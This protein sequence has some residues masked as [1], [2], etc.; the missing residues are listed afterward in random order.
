MA[1]TVG[2]MF[3]GAAT[4]IG[5]TFACRSGMRLTGPAFGQQTP[6]TAVAPQGDVALLNALGE[7][8]GAVAKSVLPAVV[9]IEAIK[10]ASSAAAGAK[11]RTIDDSGSG[12]I[13]PSTDGAGY[14]VITNYHVVAGAK[15]EQ[16]SINL[17]DGRLVRPTRVLGDQETDIAVLKIDGT[18]LPAA[19]LGDSD[20]AKVGQWVI[21]LGSPYGLSQTVTHGIISAR[22]RGQVSL[23]P[24]IRVKD[25]LQTDAAINPGSSGGPLVNLNGEVVG[26][27]TA[28]A[29]QSGTNSGIAF[30]IPAN[31]VKRIT[32][33]LE[34][35][36]VV[37]HGYLG[38]Q[39]APVF[40]PADAIAFGLERGTGAKVDGVAQ[41]SPASRAGMKVNDVVL[42]VD[43]VLIRNDNHLINLISMLPP[44]QKVKL[45]VWRA[46][47]LTTVEAEVGDWNA[48]KAASRRQ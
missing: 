10:P 25:F 3:L 11:A 32:R 27:N 22:D 35:R 17:A 6:I 39:L 14:V 18:S 30:S 2:F 21:A 24:N 5:G 37:S 44:G 28:I 12:V 34:Q 41:D 45:Q 33:Q 13:L 16:V 46:K 19:K 8:F 1:R 26:I 47:K 20:K 7:R 40:E 15:P 48:A 31:L 38:L 23:G 36:G 42:Q 29:S 4:V 9:S 43:S